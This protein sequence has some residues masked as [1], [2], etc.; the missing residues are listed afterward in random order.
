[1][2][3]YNLRVYT[4]GDPLATRQAEKGVTCLIILEKRVEGCDIL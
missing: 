4:L 3:P 1:M 2:Q